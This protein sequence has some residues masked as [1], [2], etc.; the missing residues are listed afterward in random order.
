MAAEHVGARLMLG[1]TSVVFFLIP[2]QADP[3]ASTAASVIPLMVLIPIIVAPANCF[4][5]LPPIRYR[6]AALP[7]YLQRRGRGLPGLDRFS[8]RRRPAL[9]ADPVLGTD[10][11]EV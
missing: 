5:W 1:L 4:G 10:N 6:T 11:H 8:L 7:F 3:R 9:G 2:A